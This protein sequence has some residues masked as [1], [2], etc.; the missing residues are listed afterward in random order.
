MNKIRKMSERIDTYTNE[1]TGEV[2]GEE[3]Y[4]INN[5]SKDDYKTI[6][7]TNNFMNNNLG[8]F[9]H[10]FFG[11]VL[12]LDLEPQMLIRFLKLCTYMNYDNILVK[13]NT[14][15]QRKIRE[16]ELQGILKL[17]RSEFYKTKKYL[18][19]NNLI[20]I[21]DDMIKINNKFAK[22]GKIKGGAYDKEV[23]RVFNEFQKLYD[24]VKPNQHK[25][26]FVFIKILPYL[27]VRFNIL[28]KNPYENEIE[29][30]KPISWT[31]LGKEIGLSSRTTKRLRTELWSLKI[32]NS[33]VIGEFSTFLCGKAIVI[34]PS[35]Y[36]KSNNIE[37]LKGIIDL[38]KISSR[39]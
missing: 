2:I 36:Y 10:L 23:V 19:E 11:N 5:K 12:K 3:R 7:G 8:Y 26:L 4:P 21:N 32:N 24:G 30:V 27:N 35:I 15:G 13:G 33:V 31:E 16:N 22:R 17:N 34:N 20:T 29:R 18:L 6:K 9:F 38:F 39:E 1:E 14:K 28:C 37:S 25:K